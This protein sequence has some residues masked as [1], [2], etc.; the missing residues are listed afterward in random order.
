[1]ALPPW[2][3][4]PPRHAGTRRT[5]V[6]AE[7]ARSP[8]RSRRVVICLTDAEAEEV[9]HDGVVGCRLFLGAVCVTVFA[10]VSIA[11]EY[12]SHKRS[13]VLSEASCLTA[14]LCDASG[15]VPVLARFDHP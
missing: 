6:D 9:A 4:E 15:S 3:P 7:G 2:Y 12:P 14:P 13:P 1:M 10:G 11:R 8:R 5:P